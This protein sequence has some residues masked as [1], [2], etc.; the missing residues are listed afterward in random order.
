MIHI[1]DERL[2]RVRGAV[3]HAKGL[4]LLPGQLVAWPAELLVVEVVHGC[5]CGCGCELNGRRLGNVDGR[6]L[7]LHGLRGL[8]S[9]APAP[10]ECQHR[11]QEQQEPEVVLVL[12]C[13]TS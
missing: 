2:A 4:A 9:L 8:L 3:R 13:A 6:Q 10:Y 11:D 7:V 1:F 5:G 12:H